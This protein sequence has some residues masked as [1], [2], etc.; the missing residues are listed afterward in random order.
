M[1]GKVYRDVTLPAVYREFIL[2]DSYLPYR[3]SVIHGLSTYGPTGVQLSLSSP[4]LL[5]RD[6]LFDDSDIEPQDASEYHPIATLH[7]S[8]QFL[9]IDTTS[10][11]APVFL[12]H[13]E[14]GSFQPQFESFAFFLKALKTP[15]QARAER[16]KIRE[17]FARIRKDC[18]PALT[19]ARKQF[20]GGKLEAAAAELDG[21]LRDRRPI[22][23]D[24]RN[25]FAAI[26][27]LCD[28]FNLRGRVFLAQ[29][30]LAAARGTFLDATACGG[31]P[32]WEAA[33]DAIVT[34]LLLRDVHPAIERIGGLHASDFPQSPRSI[35]MRNFSAQQVAQLDARAESPDLDEEER[36]AMRVLGWIT[37][38][39]ATEG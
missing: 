8:P 22:R 18:A 36:A 11:A 14:T 17:T 12:W 28:C 5:K 10:D 13:H 37:E 9:A 3:R 39:G 6:Q 23:Y 1:F 32:W 26:G 25:D 4:I 33:V 31:T 16:M 2:N 15:E 7:Q 20:D 35:V 38:P 21:V 29:G 19:R 24:G 27:I 34:S 30:L